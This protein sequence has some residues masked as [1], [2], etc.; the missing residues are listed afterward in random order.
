MAF[1]RVPVRKYTK[2]PSGCEGAFLAAVWVSGDRWMSFLCR[3]WAISAVSVGWVNSYVSERWP[4][5]LGCCG[6]GVLD[7]PDMAEDGLHVR[8]FWYAASLGVDRF[9]GDDD[10]AV[11][12]LG[13]ADGLEV[14][15]S[16]GSV[17]GLV[18]SEGVA[19][20]GGEL[21]QDVFECGGD[22]C[23]QVAV[24]APRMAFLT[25]FAYVRAFAGDGTVLD[26]VGA[27]AEYFG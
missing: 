14:A 17:Y 26:E 21:E 9:A 1:V 7:V 6:I 27:A 11:V 5:D 23:G 20:G 12:S 18:V 22:H 13:G 24:P 10:S 8:R 16:H 19:C 3:F 15:A 4:G 25:P 2:G